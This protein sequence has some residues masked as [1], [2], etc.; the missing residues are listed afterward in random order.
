MCVHVCARVLMCARV[1]KSAACC[2][3]NNRV[4]IHDAQM[5]PGTEAPR[6]LSTW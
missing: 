2:A 5:W 4:L 3:A 6:R 1:L